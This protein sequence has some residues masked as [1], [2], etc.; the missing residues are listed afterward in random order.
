M[1]DI[2]PEPHILE[3]S[4]ILEQHLSKMLWLRA[5]GNSGHPALCDFGS[6]GRLFLPETGP[7]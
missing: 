4:Q 7:Y 2:R 1:P 6:G 3:L 5:L